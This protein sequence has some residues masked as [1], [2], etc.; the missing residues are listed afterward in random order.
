MLGTKLTDRAGRQWI[1]V[2]EDGGAY[3]IAS[4]T[5]RQSVTYAELA[6]AYTV[7]N[8]PTPT[9]AQILRDRDER[10]TADLAASRA[11]AGELPDLRPGRL[12]ERRS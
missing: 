3:V 1:V 4:G 11:Q 7:T 9:E 12:W 10:A 5:D 2:Q 6:D 8:P